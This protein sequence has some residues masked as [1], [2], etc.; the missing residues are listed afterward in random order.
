MIAFWALSLFLSLGVAALVCLPLLKGQA[1][2]A[3]RAE[4]DAQVYRDQ[5]AELDRDLTRGLLDQ[6]A[7]ETTRIEISRR[8]L[9]AADEAGQQRPGAVTTGRSRALA[10][11]L[12]AG[13]LTGS[14]LL[15]GL[16]GTPG[17][18]DRPLALRLAEAEA[19]RQN[20]PSQEEAEAI[21]AGLDLG[22]PEVSQDYLALVDRLRSA[23]AERPDEIDGLRLLALHLPR[24]GEWAEAA[25]VQD[26]L[27]AALGASA[28]GAD[29]ADLA[30]NLIIA[31]GGYVSPRA[32]DVLEAGMRLDPANPRLRFYAGHALLQSGRPDLTY[33]LWIR[34][35]EE[36][37]PDA[38]WVAAIEAQIGEV[39]AAMGAPVPGGSQNEPRDGPQGGP[40]TTDI[41]A[42]GDMS[43]EDR[44]AMIEGMVAGLAD[45]LAR[46]GGPAEDWARLIRAY[47]VLGETARASAV[48]N[49]AQAVFGDDPSALSLLREAAREAEVAQ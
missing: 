31:A 25:R 5:L 1:A 40:T 42:A 49:E 30:E 29:Y 33:N 17:A 6:P 10:L 47:G 8:L 44:Q 45:R 39:A 3:S 36:G 12:M 27:V 35:L 37:P 16:I 23:M 28:T 21:A 19:A 41:E 32:E 15:Y 18:P 13:L 2:A 46:E 48:W 14:G 20:R 34:L 22:R 4:H 7:Y 26:R 24:I 38:P 43:P 9:A 11:L